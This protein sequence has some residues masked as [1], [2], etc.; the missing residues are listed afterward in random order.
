MSILPCSILNRIVLMYEEDIIKDKYALYSNIT[1]KK[2]GYRKRKKP[3]TTS[4]KLFMKFIWTLF[5]SSLHVILANCQA[6]TL[7]T[8][9]FLLYLAKSNCENANRGTF[10][11][12]RRLTL[13]ISK[14]M[15]TLVSTLSPVLQ[16]S[17]SGTSLVVNDLLT[18]VFDAHKNHPADTIKQNVLNFYSSTA[19]HDAIG[20]PH[21]GTPMRD[22][23]PNS[24]SD[25]VPTR[26][27]EN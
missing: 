25:V 26:A 13:R 20:V 11:I 14:Q 1:H 21:C 24:Q 27:P 19:I 16:S 7:T 4:Q 2:T 3:V 9:I 10:Q 12:S 22:I 23:S 5:L 18:Y 17:T 6:S 15:S 8:L